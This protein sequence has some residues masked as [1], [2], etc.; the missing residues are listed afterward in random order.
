MTTRRE[1][2]IAWINTTL[3]AYSFTTMASPSVHRGLQFFDPGTNPPPLISILPR[4]EESER[5]AYDQM[6]HVFPV[7]ISAVAVLSSTGNPS[8][9]GEA[10]LGEL[11]KAAYSVATLPAAVDDYVYS[12]GGIDSY[13]DDLSPSTITV[14]IT[15][16]VH[17]STDIGDPDTLT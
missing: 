7:D 5:N 1:T 13:P 11:I 10:V 4:P 14:G 15:I 3:S 17:Y 6:E 8:S 2:I 9:T 12:G 16:N